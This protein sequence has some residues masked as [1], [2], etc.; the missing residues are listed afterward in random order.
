[1]TSFAR[2]ERLALADLAEQLGPDT[3]TLCGDW[4][5]RDLLT[6]L[7][8]REGSPV[9]SPGIKVPFLA[10]LT[11]REM[12]RV[13]DWDW[14]DILERVRRPP[15][16]SPSAIGPVDSVGNLV[17]MFVHHED[18]RRG[19]SDWESRDLDKDDEDALWLPL[20]TLGRL[21]VRKAGVPVTLQRTDTGS[22]A[23]LRRG[24]GAVVAGLPSELVLF[25]YGRDRSHVELT[26]DDGAITALRASERGL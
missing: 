4:T 3:P 2:R 26:G 5:T 25:C 21:M 14:S 6:H 11:D 22:R 8:V 24:R 12:A 17:E 10:G 19:S 7:V 20:R 1:M 9:G 13:A 18:I 16:W 23:V 15:L